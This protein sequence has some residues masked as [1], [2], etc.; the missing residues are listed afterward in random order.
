[1]DKEEVPVQQ[2]Y[3]KIFISY[4]IGI[5]CRLDVINTSQGRLEGK[6]RHND[7]QHHW[8]CCCVWYYYS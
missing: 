7:Y 8:D 5:G 1:M 3:K 2:K 6:I 4:V